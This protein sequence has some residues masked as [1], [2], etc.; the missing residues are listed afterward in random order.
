[1]SYGLKMSK[2]ILKM[3]C[4]NNLVAV[5]FDIGSYFIDR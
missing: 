5:F 2:I 1:M 4:R 3:L